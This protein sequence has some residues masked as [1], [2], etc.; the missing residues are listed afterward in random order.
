M[1]LEETHESAHPIKEDNGFVQ[2]TQLGIHTGRVVY[3]RG[4]IRVGLERTPCPFPGAIRLAQFY[5]RVGAECQRAAIVGVQ[6][7]FP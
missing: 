7:D 3:N 2:F 5:Q 6:I 1:C 4:F